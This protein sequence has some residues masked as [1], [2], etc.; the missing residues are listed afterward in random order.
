MQTLRKMALVTGHEADLPM[1]DAKL[2]GIK[3]SFDSMYW[4]GAYY[5]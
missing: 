3:T 2:N 4:K 5:M 1:I